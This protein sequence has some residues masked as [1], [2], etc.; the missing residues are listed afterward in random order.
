MLNQKFKDS[1]TF[2]EKRVK[3]NN[4]NFADLNKEIITIK[5]LRTFVLFWKENSFNEISKFL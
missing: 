5:D 2:W 4:K 3:S 1:W